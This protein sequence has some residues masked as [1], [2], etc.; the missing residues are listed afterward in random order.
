MAKKDAYTREAAK[1][2]QELMKR[3]DVSR[4]ELARR[5]DVSP[6]YVTQVLSNSP[7][8]TTSASSSTLEKFA[9]ALDQTLVVSITPL[10]IQKTKGSGKL[11]PKKG[12]KKNV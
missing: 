4:S 6:S 10:P 8:Y 5:L 1:V 9:N 3:Q 12:G 11:T 7:S 2:I